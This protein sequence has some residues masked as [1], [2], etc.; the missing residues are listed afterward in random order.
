MI[1][2]KWPGTDTDVRISIE[3]NRHRENIFNTQ[4]KLSEINTTICQMES[5]IV[6]IKRDLDMAEKKKD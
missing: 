2:E 6:G 5:T 1:Y 3:G 4:I